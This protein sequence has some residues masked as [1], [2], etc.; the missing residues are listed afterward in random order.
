LI[1]RSFSA[2]L[3]MMVDK[4]YFMKYWAF[5]MGIYLSYRLAR[6]DFSYW[7]PI[8]GPF[9]V[10][11]SLLMRVIDKTIAD[12]TGLIQFRAAGEMGGAYWSFNMV[13]AIAFSFAASDFYLS[14]DVAKLAVG[15]LLVKKNVYSFLGGMCGLWAVTFAVLMAVIKREYRH[16]FYSTETGNTWAQ[17]FFLEGKSD[18]MRSKTVTI[19]RN[20]WRKIEP[21]VML[22]VQ[23]NWLD[24]KEEKPPWFKESWISKLPDEFVP[25]TEDRGEL[26]EMRRRSSLKGMVVGIDAAKKGG[27]SAI[28][29]ELLTAG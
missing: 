22:W 24:W 21:Q 28:A 15:E 17:R 26:R 1:I 18:Q 20:K 6:S 29:P 12:Y 14:S 8:Q 9:G 16:T 11:I 19:N 7:L 13:T 27:G 10:L 25:E 23:E 5:D 3:L 4:S 2:A